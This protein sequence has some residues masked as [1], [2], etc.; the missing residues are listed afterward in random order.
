MTQPQL[1][2]SY[3]A[4]TVIC[5]HCLQEQV[6]HVQAGSAIWSEAHQLVKCL[7]CGQDF[8]ANVPDAIIGG[9]YLP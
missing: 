6:A 4:V 1:K 5:S 2:Q 8:E 7:T 9:P 3:I